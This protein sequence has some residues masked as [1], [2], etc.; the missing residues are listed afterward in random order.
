MADCRHETTRLSKGC[1]VE[2]SGNGTSWSSVEGLVMM[3]GSKVILRSKLLVSDARKV[4]VWIV[5]AV[6][7]TTY[8]PLCGSYLILQSLKAWRIMARRTLV[9]RIVVGGKIALILCTVSSV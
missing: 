1:V 5:C 8:A 2:G 3:G 9:A 6:G 4:N 7:V